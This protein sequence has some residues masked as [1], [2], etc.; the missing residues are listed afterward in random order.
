MIAM[1]NN[2]FHYS[3]KEISQL[4]KER[5]TGSRSLGKGFSRILFR[6]LSKLPREVVNWTL[7]NV[8]FISDL[9]E[10]SAYVIN[11]EEALYKGKVFLIVLGETLLKT[12]DEEQ[13][14]TVAHEIAHCFLGHHTFFPDEKSIRKSEAPEEGKADALAMRWRGGS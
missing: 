2:S 9:N 4:V 5:G 8:I 10:F 3:L 14:L 11:L 12:S 1:R 7:E 13:D 6:S